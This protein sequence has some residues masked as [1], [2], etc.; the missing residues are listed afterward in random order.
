MEDSQVEINLSYDQL[1]NEYSMLMG[2]LGA[3]VSKHLIDEH[4]T[5]IW[6]N[7]YYYELIG[8]TK[9]AYEAR[10]Q[11]QCDRYFE[12]NPEG[13]KLL[14]EKIES[15]LAKGEKG[16]SVYLPM[17]YPDG[18]KFWIRLQAVFTDEYIGGYQVAYTTMIDVTDMMQAQKEQMRAQKN[19]ET[20]TREQEMLMSALNVSVSSHLVDE[21]YTCIWANEFYYKLIGYPKPKYEALFH[22]HADE[23]Y[24]NNP[25]GW[26]LLT[27]KV[28]SVL[29]QGG[30]KY[31]LIVP[32]KYEDGSSYWVKLVSFF[33]DQYVDG[34]RTSY[35][36]MTDVTELVQTRNELEMMMQAMK[37]SVS[38]H[39]VDEHFTVVWAN[40]FYY[41]LIGY[42]KPEYE[43]RFHNH[44]DEYFM[45]NPETWDILCNKIDNMCAAGEDSF[46]AYLPMK[47]P[48]GSSR[49]VKLVGFFTNEY[50]DGKQLAY[51]TMIDVTELLQAQRDKSVA[52]EHVPGFIVKYRILPDRIMMIDASSR[53]KDFFDVDLDHLSDADFMGVLQPESRSLIEDWLPKLRR[54]E[55][56]ELDESIRIKDKHGR[57]CWLQLHGTCID[58]IA[59]DPVYLVVYIDITDIT[60]L[61][62]LQHQLEERTEM[63]NTALE[64][65]KLANAAKSDFLSRMSHDI[66]TPMNAIAGMT[67][68]ADAH[69]REPER[70]RDCLQKIR[71]SSHHLLGLINDVLDM[72]QIESGKVSIHESSL[73]L[74]ELIREII[75]ITLPNVRTKQQIFKVHLRNISQEHFYSD[76]LRLRQILLNL[77][78]NASKFTPEKGQIIFEVEQL[79]EGSGLSFTIADTGPGIKKD[80]QEHLFETFT[81]ERDSRTDRIEGSGLGLAIVKRLTELMGGDIRLDSEPGQGSTFCVTLPM[82]PIPASADGDVDGAGKILLVDTDPVVLMEG[83]QALEDLGTEVYCAESIGEAVAQIRDRY[84]AGES[85]RMIIMDWEML[86]PDAEKVL[87][88]IRREAAGEPPLVIISAYDWS[89]IK[90]GVTAGIAGY[91]EK[92][93]FRSTFRDCMLKYLK[94]EETSGHKAVTYD[95]HDKIFLLAEDNELNREIAAELLG[96]FGARLDTAV[97]G[98]EALRLFQASAPGY[99][100][101]I[102][103]DIQMPVMNGYEAAREIRSLNRADAMTIPI[104][105]MTADAFVEDIRNAENAGMNGHMAKPLNFDTL[106][107][108]IEKYLT[109]AEC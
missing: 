3:S 36:V 25:E 68:I 43:E 82:R 24:G 10:F 1:N 12:T 39:K 37:V 54:R 107:L 52:Y 79:P 32:M 77:L 90:D 66:R 78:S 28:T 62:K 98:E 75:M 47:L 11:N 95:F 16:Y 21:H 29:E 51:T 61:R 99:Y 60:E 59:D 50:Q 17:V 108:E 94:G 101:L 103:M 80:F 92:P 76:E 65:A 64:A 74:P 91:I 104:I 9:A 93:F 23:Y 19:Y 71:L 96:G 72:S 83:R 34:Y 86:R 81:R 85:C 14:T 2:V 31:E 41:Q 45:D 105:A 97:N 106:A 102:L 109:S 35:T 49:W 73:S 89:E 5:C 67:E 7:S 27:Q 55:A 69:I 22:N 100:A 58:S 46:E 30:D 53:I 18:S 6:A 20:M 38:K 8:Y 15:S 13:W 40:D 88:Q 84:Q 56:L 70:V 26:E 87:E 42:P 57:D 33:T 48:D 44:C 63:L 4:L